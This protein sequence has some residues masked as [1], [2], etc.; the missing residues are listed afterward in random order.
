M[1][2][3]EEKRWKLSTPG[4]RKIEKQFKILM[5]LKD[6]TNGPIYVLEKSKKRCEVRVERHFKEIKAK[7]F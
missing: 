3:S 6:T 5:D 4:N 7:S 1:L 2:A